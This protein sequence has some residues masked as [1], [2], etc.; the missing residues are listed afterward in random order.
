LDFSCDPASPVRYESRFFID[1]NI[2][3]PLSRKMEKHQ[4]LQRV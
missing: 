4:P 1:P 3:A 2:V